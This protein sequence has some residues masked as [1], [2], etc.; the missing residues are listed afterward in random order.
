MAF[1]VIN[2]TESFVG[3][4]CRLHTGDG[5]CNN[6][7]GGGGGRTARRSP[8]FK[9]NDSGGR[10]MAAVKLPPYTRP[11]SKPVEFEENRGVRVQ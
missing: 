11:V 5:D 4:F 6:N 7:G 3:L 10:K 2:T 8:L 1:V 9:V